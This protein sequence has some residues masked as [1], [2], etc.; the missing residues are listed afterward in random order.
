MLNMASADG[1]D[2]PRHSATRRHALPLALMAILLAG[3]YDR[4]ALLTEARSTAMNTRLAEV[5]LGRFFTTLPR[6]HNSAGFTEIDVHFFGAVP[7]YQVPTVTKQLKA[8]EYRLRHET[9]AAVRS[10]TPDELAEP[11]L[12]KF[13]ARI[14]RV[15]NSILGESPIDSIGFYQITL[16]QR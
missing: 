4:E 12:T 11:N 2:R 14:E 10:A 9:L 15:V 1:I 7:R 8:E 3:C 5:D 13:R 6:P 16:R